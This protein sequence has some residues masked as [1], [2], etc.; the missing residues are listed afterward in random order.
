MKRIMPEPER[1]QEFLTAYMS[2]WSK[3]RVDREGLGAIQCPVLLVS[4]DEDDHAP[5]VTVVR[6]HQQIPNSRL[7]IVPKAW[8]TAFLDNWP[9]TVIDK[10]CTI[11]CRVIRHARNI[12]VVFGKK[13]P[14]YDT[15]VKLYR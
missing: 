8:H 9:V 5:V 7:C 12:S 3:M 15:F 4:G 10:F 11:A 1:L 6:A 13:C 14:Y 2:F